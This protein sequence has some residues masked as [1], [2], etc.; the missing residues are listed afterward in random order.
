MNKNILIS[1]AAGFIGS[2]LCDKFIQLWY[3]V[4]WVDNLSTGSVNNIQHLLQLPE[5]KFINQ[6]ITSA[7]KIEEKLDYILHFASPA[8]PIDYLQIPIE[9][10]RVNSLGTINMMELAR[11]KNSR[12]LVASTSEIYG[13]PL[14]HPQIEEYWW[15]VSSIWPRSCYDEW[16]RFLEAVTMAYNRKHNIETRIV[17]IFNTYWPRMRLDDGRVI[18]A[19][20]WQILRGEDITIF[21]DGNQT[22][23]FCYI[24]DLVEGVYKLLLSEHY[25]PINI[26]NPEE[27][28]IKELA[29]EIIQLTKSNQKI[30][31]KELPVD[32]PKKRKPNISKANNILQWNPQTNRSVGILK[33]F[34][35][36]KSII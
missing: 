36:F 20:I 14:V 23:S 15:N 13:D 5:F 11:E 28:T 21:G 32:D 17:R 7:L 35:Y 6:D 33:T 26:G 25:L 8:S 27:I 19:F 4:L 16:K 24:D 10:L 34:E 3:S 31:T 1:W 29:K 12:I 2:H 9:T 30:V 22:R 18:P